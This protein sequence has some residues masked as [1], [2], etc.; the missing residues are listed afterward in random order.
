LGQLTALHTCTIIWWQGYTRGRFQAVVD[1]DPPTLA[2]ESP[3]IRHRGGPPEPT[4][5]NTALVETLEQRLVDAGWTPADEGGDEWFERAFTRPYAE[6]AISEPEID[7]P[8][9]AEAEPGLLDELRAELREARAAAERERRARVEAEAH[10]PVAEPPT[11]PAAAAR[12]VGAVAVAVY[13]L[14][15]GGAAVVFLVGFHAPY[16]AAVAALAV[17]AVCLGVDSRRAVQRANASR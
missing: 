1:T 2:A 5:G 10:V 9:F 4:A 14:A 6:P 3:T 16:A 11:E 17:S 15:V 8:S 7:A 12:T 13:A